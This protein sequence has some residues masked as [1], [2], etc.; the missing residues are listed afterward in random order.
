MGAYE[1]IKGEE[2]GVYDAKSGYRKMEEEGL[3][4][5]QDLES[6]TT[7]NDVQPRDALVTKGDSTGRRLVSLDVFRGITVAL[8]ILVDHAGGIFPAINHSPWNGVTLA[9]FVMPFFLFIVGVSLGLTYKRLSNNALATKKAVV[10]AV[11]LL[12][13]GLIL[14]GGYIHRVFDLSYGVDIA[15]IRWM[16][17]LQRIAIAYLVAAICEIW[18]KDNQDVISGF[19]LL[20]K[21]RLQWLLALMISIIYVVLLYGLYVPDWE[22]QILIDGASPTMKTYSVKCGVRGDTGPACNAVGMIDRTILGINHLYTRPIYK[23]SKECSMLSPDY[24]PLPPNA[25]SWCQAPF[26]PEGLLSSVMAIVTC[27]IGLHFGHVLVHFKDHKERILQ[28]MMPSLFFVLVGFSMD[29]S[30]MYLNKAL[31]SF[32]YMCVTA[33]VAGIAFTGVYVMVDVYSYRRSTKLAEWMGVNALTIYILVACNVV[34]IV[35]QGFYWKS[36][37]NN[38][39]KLVGLRS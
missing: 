16:G 21:Y 23:R 24:G 1:L 19:S 17:I 2:N 30:G 18:L 28:W 8:M 11:K 38:I 20:K 3:T 14:Q 22:F 25:P 10:R 7:M 31:Y 12:A 29:L 34:P 13:L 9:D 32:S 36:P 6:G 35:L 37:E 27:I 5:K 15:H 39:F 26:D 33:G 4:R